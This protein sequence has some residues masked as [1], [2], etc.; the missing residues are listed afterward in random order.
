M[1]RYSLA[2]FIKIFKKSLDI[3][4]AFDSTSQKLDHAATNL[5]KNVFN[6]VASSLFKSDRLMFGLHLVRGTKPE[7][8]D[9]NE[10]DFF[11]G[12]T[13]SIAG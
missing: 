4:V 13:A 10:W 5:Y 11:L 12:N 1:Y 6:Q 3:Q 2:Y 7:L 8:F 9:T